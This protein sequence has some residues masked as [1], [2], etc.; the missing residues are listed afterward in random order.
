MDTT[1]DHHASDSDSDSEPTDTVTQLYPAT[2]VERENRKHSFFSTVLTNPPDSKHG[3]TGSGTQGSSSG[4]GR[5]SGEPSPAT[6][7]T[8]GQ[9]LLRL[10]SFRPIILPPV[11]DPV[12]LGILTPAEVTVLFERI[13][14]FLNPF[15]NLLDPHL[16]TPE[17]VRGKCKFLY[18]LLIMAG[19]KF[20]QCDKYKAVQ[21][22]AEEF[23]VR[24]FVEG[25]KRVEVVQAF[26]C[27]TYWKEPD[28]TV[29]GLWRVLGDAKLFD[30]GLGLLL[31]MRRGWRWS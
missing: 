21:K 11:H 15:V 18:T 24:A 9:S 12:E 26:M 19:C 3:V 1:L 7:P 27:M 31:G 29:S 28:D 23:C 5:Q 17:Y 13:F 10:P 8:S 30:S 4:N 25:W 6:A 22:L 20:W 16:H 2:M 14:Q